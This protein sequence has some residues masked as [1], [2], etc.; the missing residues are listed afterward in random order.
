MEIFE[1]IR[2]NL[3]KKSTLVADGAAEG[4]PGC[5][6]WGKALT[7]DGYGRTRNPF[8]KG[9]EIHA[10]RLMFMV[11]SHCKNLPEKDDFG[12]ILNVSHLCHVKKCI[13]F[14]HLVLE[15]DT[16]NMD[17]R[18]CVQQQACSGRHQPPCIF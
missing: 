7:K 5:I 6:L 8:E 9:K 16:T 4:T 15:A 18:Y 17:R 11:V 2:Q 12:R 10:H 3:L 1:E 13:N 14:D